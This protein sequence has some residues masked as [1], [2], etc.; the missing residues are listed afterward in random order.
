M[1]RTT[2]VAKQTSSKLCAE[3]GCPEIGT[4]VAGGWRCPAH[5]HEPWA[6]WRAANPGRSSGYGARWRRLRDAYIAEHP[7]CS[8][9]QPAGEVH[10]V[11]HAL[12][13]D[14]SFLAWDNLEAVCSRCH[15]RRGRA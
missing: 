4:D 7:T 9:G 2:A 14:S 6:A 8:C 5:L 13:T 11:D 1:L 12:P 10:H 3:P 15:R